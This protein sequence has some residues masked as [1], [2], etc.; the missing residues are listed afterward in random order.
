MTFHKLINDIRGG[1]KKERVIGAEYTIVLLCKSTVFDEKA[2]IKIH[3]I[4]NIY[5]YYK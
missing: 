5:F 4:I 3:F 1:N 2:A